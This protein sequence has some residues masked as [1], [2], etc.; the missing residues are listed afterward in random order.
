MRSF[1]VVYFKWWMQSGRFVREVIEA[2]SYEVAE[3]IVQ[4]RCHKCATTFEH[5]DV[6]VVGEANSEDRISLPPRKLS[7]PDLILGKGKS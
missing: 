5:W 6:C 1:V 3:Q 2:E 4:A 7:W